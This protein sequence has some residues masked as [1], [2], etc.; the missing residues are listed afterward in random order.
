MPERPAMSANAEAQLAPGDVVFIGGA[1]WMSLSFYEE[2]KR[3]RRVSGVY[4]C[5][6]VHDVIPI[7]APQYCAGAFPERFERWLRVIV[8][9]SDYLLTNSGASAGDLK[10]WLFDNGFSRDVGIVRLAHQFANK[11]RD[12]MVLKGIR[13]RVRNDARVPYALCVGTL[14]SRKNIWTLANIWMQVHAQLG[15]ATPRLIFAGKLGALREDFEDFIRGTGSLYGYIRI[16]E[17][18]SDDELAYLYRNC[19]FSVYP[20]Y[21]E[22]WGLPIGE[23]LWF[24]RPVICSST[25]SMP[26]VGGDLADYIDPK[27][28]ESILEAVLKM[29][30]DVDYRER[31]AAQISRACLRSW[32]DVADD[33]WCALSKV[34][35]AGASYENPIR[36]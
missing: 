33:L 3:V 25:S 7:V 35:S 5:H 29:I 12:Y 15:V 11:S 27:C 18:P 2:L 17:S 36:C 13:D 4:V 6:Y 21:I 14:E 9:Q 34:A 8:G 19:L 22:G 28:P 23:C 16:V 20:S 31:R 24:G 26:E 1:T 30:T 10:R 32:T